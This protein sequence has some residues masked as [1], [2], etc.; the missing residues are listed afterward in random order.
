MSQPGYGGMLGS[1]SA[2][3]SQSGSY[4]GL[5]AHDRLVSCAARMSAFVLVYGDLAFKNSLLVCYL[6]VAV[7]NSCQKSQTYSI[8]FMSFYLSI[9]QIKICGCVVICSE[10]G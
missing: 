1:S 6:C 4:G 2:H 7:E 9:L 3:M 10:D 5:H 8:R